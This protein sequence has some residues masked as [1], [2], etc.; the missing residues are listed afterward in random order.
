M[1][2]ALVDGVSPPLA[3]GRRKP[4]ASTAGF[5]S[6]LQ[7]LASTALYRAYSQFAPRKTRLVAIPWR[8]DGALHKVSTSKHTFNHR[9]EAK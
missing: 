1:P 8:L 3:E 7:Q 2:L 5:N 4:L 6:S 9:K